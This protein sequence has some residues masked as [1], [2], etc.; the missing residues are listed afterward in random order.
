MPKAGLSETRLLRLSKVLQ[1]YVDRGE[2]AGAVAAVHRK[3]KEAY[4]D[5]IGWQDKE[6]RIP[7]RR[8]TI[9]R[10]MSMTKPITAAAALLLAEEGKIR[11]HDPVDAWLPELSGRVVLRDPNGRL[12][13]VVPASR[14]ITLHDLLTSRIGIGWEDHPLQSEMMKLLPAPLAKP[15]GEQ[16][17]EEHLDPDSW[18]KR[19]SELPLLYQPGTRFLY[20]IAHEVLGVL[21]ARV[22]GQT[23]DA[24]YRERIFEPLGMNDTSFALPPEK[25]GRLSVAYA[26]KAEGG[27][28]ELDRPE[29]TAWA[30]APIFPSGGAG[31]LSTAD[32]YRR[33]GRMLLGYGEVDGVRMLSRKSV[34]AMITDHLAPEQRAQPFFDE[35][36]YDGSMMWT[37]KGYGYGVSVRTKQ[38]GIGPG[39][40][41]FFWPGALGT[42]WIADP[43]E[44]L[45]ATL[46]IQLRGA[47]LPKNSLIAYDFW[48]MLYQAI[49]D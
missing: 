35:T 9:F 25:R 6:A 7:V 3:G 24:F 42:T 48:T 27:L 49:I 18:M 47:Q 37:N 19:L 36:D 4:A 26:P 33:F 30:E 46:M 41:S 2:I 13:D 31:L 44:E 21:I 20:H 28:I 1:D 10:I 17:A 23:L 12:D 14:P 39:I 5:A 40:G 16:H 32:D 22:S 43:R 11:L 8:D 38:I 29:S 45:M 34:E 15:L